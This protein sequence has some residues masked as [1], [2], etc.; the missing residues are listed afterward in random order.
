MYQ[1]TRF[2]STLLPLTDMTLNTG[3]A[4]ADVAAVG[5]VGGGTFDAYGSGVAP[6]KF[7]YDLRYVCTVVNPDADT[8][9]VT[10]RDLK[11]LI[12]TRAKLWRT[13]IPGSSTHWA[14]A[15]LSDVDSTMRGDMPQWVVPLT[16]GFTVMGRWHG[17]RHQKAWF[18]DDG[19]Y[20]D[21]GLAFDSNEETV[22]TTSPQSVIVDND[23]RMPVRDTI[24]NVTAH[25]A[26]IT[27]LEISLGSC[28]WY[29]D[30]TIAI[31]KTLVIDCGAKSVRND[32]AASWADLH[33]TG[34]H[35]VADWLVLQ[36]GDNAVVVT[37][38]GGGTTSTIEFVFYD[39]WA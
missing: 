36:P 11:S 27:R 5:L 29:Y 21:D 15:R 34:N 26:P 32:G 22:L 9:R 12:G 1:L 33:L 6:Q 20:F 3:T 7:P 16:L 4:P 38:T 14:W 23:G 13:L 35:V 2:G 8:A 17:V 31:D 19:N 39:G 30:G 25:V 24:I 37:K 18:F 10:L 28:N